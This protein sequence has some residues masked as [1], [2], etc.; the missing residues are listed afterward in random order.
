MDRFYI[1]DWSAWAPGVTEAEDWK[2]WADGKLQIELSTDKPKLGHLPPVARRRLSQLSKM[3]LHVGHELNERN[4]ACRTVLC[5]R[6]G[7]IV[8]QNGITGKLIETGEVRPAAFSLSVFNTPVSLLSIH[9]DN[10]E[11]ATVLLSGEN[12]FSTGLM[13]LLADIRLDPGR[14]FMVIFADEW[15]PEDY[16]ELYGRETFPYA[17]A[18]V[19]GA[20]ESEN[21][22]PVD[23]DVKT[24]EGDNSSDPLD[25]LR[26]ILSERTG[27]L[28]VGGS[29][30]RIVLSKPVKV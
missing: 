19:A 9:E 30:C 17:F 5:S 23:V 12:D 6:F 26:W 14:D 20:S 7:E 29:G 27:S 21:S 4:G 3:V 16:R 10:R 15:L 11:A 28:S 8:Q 25:L 2:S 18:M 24:D 1:K 22:I 13:S